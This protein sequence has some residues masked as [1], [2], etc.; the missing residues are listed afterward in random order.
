MQS[1]WG[2][3]FN[4][5]TV[6]TKS[7]LNKLSKPNKVV[8]SSKKGISIEQ[9][10]NFINTEVKRILGKYA[11]NTVVIRSLEQFNDFITTAILND[12]I[13]I[14]T[15]TNNSLQP[16]SCKLMG[17]C[18]YTPGQKNVY[19][20][21]NHVNR[22]TGELLP[23]QLTEQDIYNQL[24]RLKDTKIIMHNGKF[25]YEVIKCT[26]G[27]EL[28][29]YWDTIIGA[30]ILNE[31]EP[32]KLKAQYIS[33][34]D[35]E[36]EKYSIEDLFEGLEYAIFEP[37][38]FA[39]Y[40]ATDSYMTY[41]LYEWQKNQ[42][43]KPEN[44]NLYSL[45]KNIEMAVLI[46]TAEM[47]LNG[48]SIDLEFTERL[49][50]KYKALQLECDKK[51]DKEL[52]NY[53]EIIN[54]W[55]MSPE[56]NHHPIS[57]KPN[58]KGEYKQQKSKNEQLND[59][60]QLTSPTQFAILLYDV[61]KVPMIDK[62]TPRGT[63]EDILAKID[64]P[65]CKLVLEK[66]TI[67]K[68]LSTYIEKLPQC[69]CEKDNK[70]HA[71]FN[72]LGADTGRFS[73]DSP[74]LQNIP[75]KGPAKSIRCMFQASPG[76][77]MVGADFS[78]QEPKL[79]ATYA[80][81]KNMIQ[82][83]L[84]G[85]DLYA[86]IGTKVYHNNY[87]DNKE[88]DA[89]G[90]LNPEGKKRRTACKTILLGLMY[91]RGAH[92]IAEQIGSTYEEAQEIIDTFYKEF[93]AVKKWIDK[94]ESDAYKNGYV[95]DL[96]GRRRRLP[97][98]QLDRYTFKFNHET[99]DFNPL[100]FSKGIVKN[101]NKEL[102]E[103]YKLQL[104]KAKYRTEVEKI[105]ADA[106]KNDITIINNGGFISRA[107]RQCVNARI[108]G[109]AASMSKRA[110]ISLYNDPVMNELGFKL[111][112]MVHDELIGECPI[113]NLDAV[114]ERLAYWMQEAGKPEC[115]LPMKTDVAEFDHWYIDECKST[116]CEHYSMETIDN[117]MMAYP[118]FSKEQFIKFFNGD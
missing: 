89:N 8:T 4:V 58:K 70:I 54:T 69:I 91:G 16:V 62:K 95:E 34:I 11:D 53:K 76:C 86:V 100:L 112:I 74:N 73:S 36:Q 18:L 110:M 25:D 47:E 109:G 59:P 88:F 49:R 33:K 116:I 105:K 111:L 23:N 80:Q 9:K 96:W 78:A 6:D 57:T 17:L 30:R 2:D 64:L 27:N 108:Q 94:T 101:T 71:S 3:N 72:Q 31:N 22:T 10:I 85:K 39:L 52:E 77:I 26:C 93:P 40:A 103:K 24:E 45:F 99:V 104:E 51:I 56:A 44:K 21:V 107:Q 67:E 42:F 97:D 1:L 38:I 79:L 98:I 68:L 106:L 12:V 41:R 84:D 43:E 92:S 82:A 102:I 28:K 87:E 113:E 37:E 50:N 117:A 46:P 61:L 20:P 118:E 19:I 55:R 115:S 35:A 60:P 7:I 90:K 15:E 48:I 65:L 114:K 75:A 5:E 63:G 14:D 83:Y 13:A 66:R 29:I 32:A 81:D